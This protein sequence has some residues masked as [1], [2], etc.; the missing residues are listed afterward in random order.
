MDEI[1]KTKDYAKEQAG[2]TEDNL[3]RNHV[4]YLPNLMGERAPHND[5]MA[6]SCFIGMTIDTRAE[7]LTQ[8]VPEDEAFGIRGSLG[9]Q[10]HWE[11]IS[12]C[13]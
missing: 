5:P 4:Y 7:D 1:L 6:G 11:S 12:K 9:R 10:K 13:P 2:I 8:T 3:G